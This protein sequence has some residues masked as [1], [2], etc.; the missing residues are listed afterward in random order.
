MGNI[1]DEN[2]LKAIFGEEKEKAPEP[3]IEVTPEPL[4]EVIEPKVPEKVY[5]PQK[6]TWQ[7]LVKF[8]SLFLGIFIVSYFSIN[9]PA[10]ME[11]MRYSW[12]VTIK[13]QAYSKVASTPTPEPFNAT[14]DAR[15]VIPKIGV[16]VPI[17]WNVQEEDFKSKLLEGVAHSQGTALPGV[18]GNIF[19]TGHSSYYSWV[20]SPYKDVFALL[21]K[22]APGDKVYI[23]YNSKVF[24]YDVSGSKVVASNESEVMNQGENYNLTLMTC[25]P[26]GTNLN[27]LVVI[28]T[29][30][31]S[32]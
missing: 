28:A 13:R 1:L 31:S 26:I 11:K 3:I 27:R 30:T 21:D 19:I 15:L 2:D 17:A 20:N 24:T 29:Q 16:D 5:A 22:L 10:L 23:K 14:A 6:F 8:L 12:D 18:R 4:P 25:V 32:T 9:A 7:T